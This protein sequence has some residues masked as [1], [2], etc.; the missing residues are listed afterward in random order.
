MSEPSLRGPLFFVDMSGGRKTRLNGPPGSAALTV[1]RRHR[2]GGAE[3]GGEVE[4]GLSKMAFGLIPSGFRRV[5]DDE[6]LG[7]AQ[8]SEGPAPS[9]FFKH[10][11][12]RSE[13]I[14]SRPTFR[15]LSGSRCVVFAGGF[16]EWRQESGAKQ[17]YFVHMRS[18]GRR[19]ALKEDAGHEGTAAIA[20]EKEPVMML[21]AGL[22]DSWKSQLQSFALLTRDASKSNIRWLHDRV[23][24]ILESEE[25]AANWLMEGV[26]PSGEAD[27]DAFPVTSE[28]NS[29]KFEPP[30]RI[31]RSKREVHKNASPI[32][33]F[34]VR[35]DEAAAAVS[36][37]GKRSRDDDT[38]IRPTTSTSPRKAMKKGRDIRSFFAPQSHDQ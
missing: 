2:A 33:R 18:R 26:V 7:D 13:S 17:P 25:E 24:V 30:E 16:V 3:N 1:S 31:E 19:D 6:A 27:L 11:N 12:A 28:M 4:I 35:G 14:S 22:F 20:V 10:F 37:N 36:T 15:R 21:M 8:L 34:L 38:G 5:S 32:A 9:D 23:P 29:S